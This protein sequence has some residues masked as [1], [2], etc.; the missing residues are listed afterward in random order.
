MRTQTDE[1]NTPSSFK[2]GMSNAET[3]PERVRQCAQQIAESGPVAVGGLFDLTSQRLVRFS[4]AITRNQHDAEDAVQSVLIRVTLNPELLV[5]TKSPWAYLLQMV[6]NESL[7]VLRKRK[8]LTPLGSILDLLTKRS[9]DHLEK[10]D[11]YRLIWKE[12]RKLPTDQCEVIVLR[13]W[14]DLNF[15]EIAEILE[16]PTPTVASRYRY[17]L[18][19][20]SIRLGKKPVEVVDV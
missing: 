8:R 6:R 12:L 9:V 7:A 20:L 1:Q 3:L 16:I 2:L 13:I 14:E 4:A 18:E 10:E 17:G 15:R 5:Q 19:K 11:T